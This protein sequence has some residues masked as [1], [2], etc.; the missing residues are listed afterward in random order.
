MTSL[1]TPVASSTNVQYRIYNYKNNPQIGLG[2]SNFKTNFLNEWIEQKE[3]YLFNGNIADVRFYNLTL[4]NSD[5]KAISKNYLTNEFVGINWNIPTGTRAYI[6]E[7][8]RFFLHRMPG[9]KSQFFNIR[10]KNSGLTDPNVR[11]IV[12]NNLLNAVTQVAPAYTK[13]RSIIWE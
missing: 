6:E 12:E 11:K 9:S 13:L 10:I 1:V 2:T 8:E 3:Q 7:I 5:I 4:T